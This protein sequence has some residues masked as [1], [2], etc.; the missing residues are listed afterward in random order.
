MC[1]TVSSANFPF[2]TAYKE[3]VIMRKII[4]TEFRDWLM[5]MLKER[6]WSQS[7]LARAAKV[8]PTAI[9]DIIS[10]RRNIGKQTARAIAGA[11]KIPPEHVFRLAGILPPD[12]KEDPWVQEIMAKLDQ[13][14]PA[15]R[16]IAEW[17]IKKLAEDEEE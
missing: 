1:Y 11:L 5:K 3:S 7:D 4:V 2:A 8:S 15:Q 10:G 9:S 13:L 6:D 16:K 12:P 17:M 14:H